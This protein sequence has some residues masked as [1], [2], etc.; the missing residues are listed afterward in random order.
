MSLIKIDSGKHTTKV[1]FEEQRI[2]FD[3]KVDLGKA[4]FGSDTVIFENESYIVGEEAKTYDLSLSKNT[5]HHQILI[6]TGIGNV[7]G[8]E[9]RVNV[10]LGIPLILFFNEDEKKEY[11]ANISNDNEPITITING[12]RKTFT[13]DNVIVCPETLGGSLNDFSESKKKIRGVIDIGGLNV[14]GII[15]DKGRPVRSTLF[16]LNKG[17][18]ILEGELKQ[19]ITQKNRKLLEDYVLKDYL[20]RGS[21]DT[22]IQKIIDDYCNQ[23]LK[24]IYNECLRHNWDM[25]DIELYLMGGGSILLEKYL[26]NHFNEPLFANDVFANVDAFGIFAENKLNRKNG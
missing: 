14:N 19:Q 18:H 21:K 1:E 25:D 20:V 2:S 3:S 9:T 13:I 17:T 15:Y 11:I 5:K 23:F 22:K 6:Y 26:P 24:E 7:I 16:T 8:S 4:Q 10:S 12:K